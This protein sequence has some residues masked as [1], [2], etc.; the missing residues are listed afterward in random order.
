MRPA[1][2]SRFIL[3]RCI[4]GGVLSIFA[5]GGCVQSPSR[6][7]GIGEPPLGRVATLRALDPVGQVVVL[8]NGRSCEDFDSLQGRPSNSHY[9]RDDMGAITFGNYGKDDFAV[10]AVGFE[11]GCI[12]DLGTREE[13][14]QRYGYRE[15]V[16]NGCGFASI[17]R[18]DGHL[19]IW[20]RDPRAPDDHKPIHDGGVL[21]L[22]PLLEDAELMK[23]PS[24]SY[25]TIPAHLGH[26][27][28]LRFVDRPTPAPYTPIP[29]WK[30]EPP[31]PDLFVKPVVIGHEPGVS[32]TFRWLK[33]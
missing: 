18:V 27:Y 12:V 11:Y 33:L 8:S 13:L 20:G 1:Y 19:M 5:A 26:I 29:G 6:D 2:S 7:D 9:R 25:T 23:D 21:Q 10:G 15:P 31:R 32:V 30:P 24:H 14:E 4:G 17:S 16:G 28:L 3:R 22:Q